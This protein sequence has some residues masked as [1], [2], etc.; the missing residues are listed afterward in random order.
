MV[1][2]SQEVR[3]D[4]ISV[5]AWVAKRSIQT[6]KPAPIDGFGLRRDGNGTKGIVWHDFNLNGFA[7]TERAKP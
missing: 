4:L 2:L 6:V 1:D 7:R 5:R 3:T